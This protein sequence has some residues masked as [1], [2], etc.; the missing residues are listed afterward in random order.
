MLM[1][2]NLFTFSFRTIT[3]NQSRLYKLYILTVVAVVSTFLALELGVRHFTSASQKA[4]LLVQDMPQMHILGREIGN[5]FIVHNVAMFSK[6]PNPLSIETG[7][8]GTSRSKVLRPEHFGVP[9][10]VVGAGNSYN[11]ITYGLLLQA[12]ILRLRF[13]NLKRVYFETS[14]LLRRPARLIVEEDHRKYLPLLRTL[15]PLC[16]QLTVNA[17]CLQV[18]SDLNKLEG[19][20]ETEIHSELLNRRGELRLTSLI[21]EKKQDGIYVLEDPLLANLQVNG[22]RK[23]LS[24]A[25][26]SKNDQV[27]EITTD[28]IKVQRLRDILSYGAGDEVF[29]LIALWGNKH[30]I[31]VIFFQPPVRSD[32]YRYKLEYGLGQHVA[33]IERIS[34]KFSIPFINLN[35][36]ELGYMDDW[37]LFSDEDHL[38]T[39]VGS[40]LLTLALEE[41]YKRFQIA[42][43]IFPIIERQSLQSSQAS[44]LMICSQL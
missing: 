43:E 37:S 31:Q 5:Q 24:R 32:L 15:E 11:E 8:V 23:H 25:T 35:K 17:G 38:E 28:N 12:E 16:K 36:P 7:Y 6:H 41:G 34:R 3:L 26:I 19:S 10:S 1:V 2:M 33:D 22:E 20:Y 18:F 13:P 39:C 44:K 14:M 4:K 42:H 40:G 27:Q 9:A 29:D 21:S 30:H